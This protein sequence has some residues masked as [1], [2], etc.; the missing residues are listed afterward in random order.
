MITPRDR[1]A[2]ISVGGNHQNSDIRL[3]G[4]TVRI[5]CETFVAREVDESPKFGFCGKFGDAS[6]DGD[7]TFSFFTGILHEPGDVRPPWK[8]REG[9]QENGENGE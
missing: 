8:V 6:V 9:E 1:R 2:K 5:I 4:A 3:C 7:P